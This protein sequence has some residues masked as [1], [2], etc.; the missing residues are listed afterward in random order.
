V[1]RWRRL[2][3]VL[4]CAAVTA[5]V[6]RAAHGD[7]VPD[8]AGVDTS[9]ATYSSDIN[10][11]QALGET[12]FAPDTIV[13]SVTL[14]RI[15]PEHAN[16]SSLKFWITEV[17]SAEVPHTHLVVYEGPMISVVSPDST[18]PTRLDFTFDPPIVLPRVASYCLWAQEIC[19]GY[20][21]LVIDTNDGYAA[22]SLW[23]TGISNFEGCILRDFPAPL[24]ADLVFTV[25]F[26][27]PP[28]PTRATTWGQLKVR[29]R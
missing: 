29:Y 23:K 24:P 12:F 21:D 17:D 19:A 16:P 6:A 18:R 27:A 4:W 8:S 28:T 5:C 3:A 25:R 14:W 26:C 15:P 13:T 9:L 2:H 20:A 22:G 10:R 7:C 11:G 1:P